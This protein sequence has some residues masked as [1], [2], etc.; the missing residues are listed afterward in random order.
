M[1]VTQLLGAGA[2]PQALIKALQGAAQRRDDAIVQLL[3]DA[4][5]EPKVG[6]A[7]EAPLEIVAIMGYPAVVKMLLSAGAEV[8]VGSC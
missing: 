6:S 3:L 4:S 7:F 2:D 1:V 8:K 5:A